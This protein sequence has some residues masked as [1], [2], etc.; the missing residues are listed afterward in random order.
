MKTEIYVIY[1][2]V[3]QESGPIFEAKNEAVAQRQFV[4]VVGQAP[5][6]DDFR[7]LRIGVMEHDTSVVTLE[8]PP[9]E[10]PVVVRR[11]KNG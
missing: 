7:L 5:D 2:K 6:P 10:V 11:E 1:D 4:R 3:A 9:V 8:V